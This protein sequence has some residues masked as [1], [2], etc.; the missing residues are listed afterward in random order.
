METKIIARV[1]NVDI[2]STSDEQMVAIRPICEALGI[3]ANGQKQRIERDEI[4]SSTACMIHAVAADGKDR[5]MYAIPFRYVFGWL[6]SIDISKV[7]EEAREFVTRYKQECYDTLYEHFTE[8]QTF[9]KQKQEVMEKKVTEY[10][11]CQRRFKDA[12]KLMNEA[13]TDL[14]QVMK[15]T[16]DDW[17]A[18]HCQLNLPF[19]TEEIT[20]E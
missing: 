15:L 16:I 10:Q 2:V 9:L 3:D 5:E 14:N 4:L 18:N 7:N 20:E 17:R 13:K 8:P 19:T 6:F 11:E 12:Q 1:N